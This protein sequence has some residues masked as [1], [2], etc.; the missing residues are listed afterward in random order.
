MRLFKVEFTSFVSKEKLMV[1]ILATADLLNPL[2]SFAA[3][4]YASAASY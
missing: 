2:G 3:K 4:F 1:H